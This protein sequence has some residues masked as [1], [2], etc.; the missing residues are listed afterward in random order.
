[1]NTKA[2]VIDALPNGLVTTRELME[3]T[4]LPAGVVS[5]ILRQLGAVPVVEVVSNNGRFFIY[6]IE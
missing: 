2:Q 1:M 4:G 6:E 3:R 5:P